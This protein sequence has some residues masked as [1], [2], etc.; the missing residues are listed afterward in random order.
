MTESSSTTTEQLQ[1]IEKFDGSSQAVQ[2]VLCLATTEMVLAQLKAVIMPMVEV[3]GHFFQSL[4]E[5][6]AYLNTETVDCA[7]VTAASVSDWQAKT[8]AVT[9]ILPT[10]ALIDGE[11]DPCLQDCLAL[12]I[13]DYLDW[14]ILS[15]SQL[16]RSFFHVA[17][18]Q[19]VQAQNKDLSRTLQKI[20]ERYRLTLDA[21]K[22]GIWDWTIAHQDIESNGRLWE[23][24]G[25]GAE[26]TPLNFEDF[27]RRIHP[28]DYL[29]TKVAF[30]QH[31]Y[32]N[33]DFSVE[34]RLRHEQGEY[35]DFWIRGQLQ[36][37]SLHS[38]PRM[39]GLMTD[40]TARKRRDRRSRFLSQASSLL[41]ASLDC[42]ATLENLAWLAVPRIA[43]WCIL[44]L[45]V[46]KTGEHPMVASHRNPSQE[47]LV[48]RFFDEL[49]LVSPT[50]HI[51]QYS[52]QLSTE[53]QQLLA[54]DYG[55]SPELIEQL[56]LQSYIW[57]P[58]QVGKR[59]LGSIF[60]AWGDSHRA[61][62]SEDL[63][64]LQEL[65]YRA[66]WSI[67]NARLYDERQAVYQDLQ[68]AIA[69]LTTQQ[70]RLKT[71][72]HL[73]TLI[74]QRL[75]SIPELLKGIVHQICK[76]VPAAQ[77]C[78]IALYDANQE[79]DFFVV[80]DGQQPKAIAFAELLHQDKEWLL[81][82]YQTGEPYLR[83][84][85]VDDLLPASL[86]AVAIESVSSGRLG[87][88]VIGNWQIA[89]AF[90]IEDCEFLSAVG[91][92]AAIAIDNARLI[93]TLEQ[94]NQEL[95]ETSRVKDLF[96]AT[97]SHELRTP[98][99]AILGFSQ[100]LLNQRRSFLG[101]SE[102]QIL[103]RILSNGR[104]LMAL[105]ND[106][107]DFS[108]MKLTELKLLPSAFNLESL[109][110]D[111]VA[112]LQSLA[113]E[114]QLLLDFSSQLEDCSVTHDQKRI[115]QVVVN[116][117]ANALS[118]TRQGSVSL[119]LAEQPDDD[120][121]TITVQDTGIGISPENLDDIFNEF[122]QVQQ[123]MN[124]AKSG[125][126]L[127]LAITYKLVQRMKGTI[128]VESTLGKGSRFIVTLPR[129]LNTN[130]D[131]AVLP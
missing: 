51:P 27:K 38:E 43:D 95:I 87:V 83:N 1:H 66:T 68:G 63:A 111:I 74:N 48:K 106:I 14:N 62:C 130:A 9:Q 84:F 116:L 61:C 97:V 23:M 103:K 112:E 65:A 131:I 100:V 126:G 70:K 53:Q 33:K 11:D 98:M 101:G 57:I 129:N 46:E 59:S 117:V 52:F 81:N 20:D 127:G 34:V 36:R 71:L 3:E 128:H 55:W 110:R 78:S 13:A 76:D 72:Q 32:E 42:Q 44:E 102:Q 93:K 73:T 47:S 121:V 7:L 37:S 119:F 125:T 30:K 86:A 15:A 92:E 40:I 17:R 24:L 25:L 54:T 8:H 108:Q 120:T 4:T 31:L 16:R 10:V 19:Q 12:G 94:Q 80:T 82:V 5:A 35:R 96:L 69:Q 85:Q 77:I 104:S 114:K 50:P 18:L 91:E 39:C 67:E 115:R 21:S 22:D 49:I 118:F 109:A 56:N 113:D 60:F 2:K 99:N 6:I 26:D 28:E 79:D 58:L 45:Y 88:L 105:I 107:L 89:R 123:N 124:L 90:N 64:L 75:T 41:N 122:W 29:P